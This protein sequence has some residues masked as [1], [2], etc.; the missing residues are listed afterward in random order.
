MAGGASCLC[1]VLQSLGDDPYKQEDF[2]SLQGLV[3]QKQQAYLASARASTSTLHSPPLGT[4][5]SP[6]GWDGMWLP[7]QSSQQ[8][9]S[10]SLRGEQ[11]G[12]LQ[13]ILPLLS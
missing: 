11:L 4:L 5:V 7:R 8:P 2:Q 10:G 1:V 9:F 13:T 3:S 12:S 6:Q